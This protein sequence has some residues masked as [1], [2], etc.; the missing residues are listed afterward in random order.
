MIAVCWGR[1]DVEVRGK[2]DMCMPCSLRLT[3]HS[4]ASTTA[5]MMQEQGR[6]TTAS[7]CCLPCSWAVRMS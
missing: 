2:Q 7:G 6:L 5:L 3:A 4:L 1:K